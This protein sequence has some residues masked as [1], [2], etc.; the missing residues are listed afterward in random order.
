MQLVRYRQSTGQL[1]GIY[2]S[3]MQHILDAQIVVDDPTWGFLCPEAP[4]PL[5]AQ[6][7]WEVHGGALVAKA[8]LVLTATPPTFVAD[9]VTTC[10][11]SVSPF[12]PCALQVQRTQVALTPGDTTL[13]LTSDE[14]QRFEVALVPMAG[15]WAAPITIDA[16]EGEDATPRSSCESRDGL[17]L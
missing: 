13:T 8:A 7:R 6:D 1:A 4:V 9:G 15:Y 17:V 2:E 14:A 11:V 12:V 10:V 3:N 5:D 16:T